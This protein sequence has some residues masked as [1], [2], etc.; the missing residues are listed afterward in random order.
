MPHQI[1]DFVRELHGDSEVY[2]LHAPSFTSLDKEL[3]FET[4][5]SSFVS[6]VGPFV[7]DFERRLEQFTKSPKVVATVNG[8]LRYT[9]V[10]ILLGCVVVILY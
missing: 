6:S 5:N 4:I 9:L 10:Y 8:T 1:T 7:D 2:P 3:V